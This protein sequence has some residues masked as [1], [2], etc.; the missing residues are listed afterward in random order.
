MPI[1]K[2]TLERLRKAR[3][4]GEKPES[5]A[6]R[7]RIGASLPEIPESGVIAFLIPRR[8]RRKRKPDLHLQLIL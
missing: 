4:E 5:A 1:S 7:E 3:E 2:E 6:E 8:T